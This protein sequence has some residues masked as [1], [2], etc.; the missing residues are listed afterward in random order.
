MATLAVNDEGTGMS[1]VYIASESDLVV[2][3]L[4]SALSG[5]ISFI[6]VLPWVWANKKGFGKQ[7]TDS[8]F[9]NV[10]NNKGLWY[11]DWGLNRN[12]TIDLDYAPMSWGKTSIDT[13]AKRNTLI[14]KT[15][16]THILSFN[17]ADDCTGQS[18]QWGSLCDHDTA[19]LWHKHAMKTGLLIV[20]PSCRESEELKWLKSVNDLMIPA[21]TRM[22]VIGMHW[23]DWGGYSSGAAADAVSIFNRF[24]NKVIACYNYYK[25]PIWI[26]EFNANKNR[27]TEIQ[28]AFLQLALPW[29]ESTPYVERY[30]FYQPDGGN[31]EFL[32]ANGNLT[33]KGSI[34][35]NFISTPSVPETSV[36]LYNNN[37]QSR[38][39]EITGVNNTAVENERLT[40]HFNPANKQIV[41][42]AVSPDTVSIFNLQGMSVKEI[43]PN[44]S[45]ELSELSKGI[46]ILVASGFQPEKILIY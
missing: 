33:S 1:K 29:L 9:Y 25:M 38:M 13:P 40:F 19:A 24:K 8:D 35:L 26:T 3:S 2:N 23:Y 21:G 15:R 43:T 11:Y 10:L 42:K 20:S 27:P 46:Y 32:Y 41:V 12:A 44:E 18:G 22:D 7:N 31:G 45:T 39:N 4:P 37:L 14:S 5:K 16:V 30:A 34:Y 6:R 17:E 36:N 28:D